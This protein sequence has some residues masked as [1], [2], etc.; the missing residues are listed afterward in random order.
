MGFLES[1][2]IGVSI[3]AIPGPIFFELVRRTLAKGFLYG[4]LLAVGEFL[5]N[6]ALLS[7]IF[8]G[9]SNFFANAF[10]KVLLYIIGSFILVRLGLSALTLKNKELQKSHDSK[11]SG[12][13]SILA[14]FSIAVTSP[15]VIALW[16]SLSGSYLTHSSSLLLS[17]V[18]IFFIA[19]GFL[20]FFFPLAAVI[21]FTRHKIPS[22]YII[23]LSRIFGAVLVLY[24]LS[25][26]YESVK[27]LL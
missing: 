18:N 25:F 13:N 21:H 5:G 20:L 15:I 9:V 19:F 14:G 27:L 1:I 8:L 6:F 12:N 26:L 23:W 17:F 4:S 7:L 16:I 2:I 3:A 22:Q 10:T 11:V 24:G